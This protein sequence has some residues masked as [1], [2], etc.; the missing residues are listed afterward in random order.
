MAAFAA[1]AP[2]RA[3]AATKLKTALCILPSKRFRRRHREAKGRPS[4]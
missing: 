2:A 4:N 1:D 3:V